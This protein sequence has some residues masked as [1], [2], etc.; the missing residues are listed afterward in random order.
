M[1]FRTL[2]V[3]PIREIRLIFPP[4]AALVSG[5]RWICYVGFFLAS[6]HGVTMAETQRAEWLRKLASESYAER[7]EATRQ[8]WQEGEGA[9][10]ALQNAA[11]SPDPEVAMRARDLLRKI[12]LD[13]N[14]QTDPEIIRLVDA[15]RS[16][17]PTEK[18]TIYHELRRLRAWPQILRLYSTEK[19]LPLKSNLARMIESIALVAARERIAEGD[20]EAA[21]DH[22][23]L[24][25]DTESGRVALAA[26]HRARGTIGD[27]LASVSEPADADEWR[28]KAA[29]HRVAGDAQA[30][31]GAARQAGD[32]KVAAAMDMLL[33]NPL[34]WLDHAAIHG[35]PDQDAGVA[36]YARAAAA[37]WRG[38]SWAEER[39]EILRAIR[40]PDDG[41]RL[42]GIS[43]LFLLGDVEPAWRYF[44]DLH[45]D[46]AFA[47][48]DALERVDEALAVVGLDGGLPEI[49][50]ALA[51]L[52]RN[53]CAAPENAL[54]EDESRDLMLA[55]CIS[56][57][58]FLERRGMADLLDE[59][60][61]PEMLDFA[62]RHHPQFVELLSG[63]FGVA[64]GRSG[65][66]E[67]AHR[68]ATAWA[69]DD[70]ERWSEVLIAAFG[71]EIEYNRWWEMLERVDAKASPATRM[72]AMLA[73]F[74]YTRDAE[75]LYQPWIDRI[76]SHAADAERRET[77]LA[78]FRFLMTNVNDVELVRNM[79]AARTADS[80]PDGGDV[81][82][83]EIHLLVDAALGRW[84]EIADLFLKQIAVLSERG[85]ARAELHAY[86]AVTLRNAGRDD[87]ADAHES[88]V[89]SLAL[90]DSRS[91]LAVAQAYAFGRDY[92]RAFVWYRRAV[93]ESAPGENRFRQ[94]LDG[95]LGELLERR[96]HAR[97][98]SC[99]EVL[100][101]LESK[102][103]NFGFTPA[104]LV[105]L[106]Q[107]A[108]AGRAMAMLPDRR[109]DAIELL[110]ATHALAPTDGA[111]A[112]HFF[113]ALLENPLDELRNE[114]FESSWLKTTANLDLFP[115][116]DNTINTAVWFASRAGLRL[117][118]AKTLQQRALELY[119]RSAAYLD[120]LG[121]VH[122]A[123][124]NRNEAV[125]LGQLAM[126]YVPHDAMIIRQIERFKHADLPL[127]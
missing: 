31:A 19:N 101:Q 120:T 73:I 76:W 100:A 78:L 6:T 41:T 92:E 84:S 43:H 44:S 64:G 50:N 22:L 87:E 114:L 39:N 93:M 42:S 30:A 11:R 12:D 79:R 90:G 59:V 61:L 58:G 107:Q 27:A 74:G 26:F 116:A 69:G 53:V 63:L 66:P 15:Y 35:Q 113:P 104:M 94:A 45:P 9:K 24:T 112:D 1:R 71:G 80:P 52:V 49:R 23:Q 108:D 67:L 124:G 96:Q 106:R 122:F 36:R 34:P 117:G 33:G 54:E 32:E 119:P 68:I 21:R 115:D 20:W 48:F 102:E 10:E 40:S 125:R 91:N 111:L 81:E 98:A 109:S 38:E 82:A 37:R 105:R 7:V 85:D 70:P 29:L 83:E 86:A 75:G 126:R 88:W 57:C 14:P 121:E 2:D 60:V 3:P 118:E 103:S 17:N 8:L 28:W 97:V 89:E 123:L 110:R 99:S 62:A 16:A 95:Y 13:I 25:R 5:V 4:G 47:S 51:E 18:N 77:V 56:I 55:R 46:E 127:R 72:Q 65:A